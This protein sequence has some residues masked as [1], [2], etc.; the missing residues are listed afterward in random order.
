V[1]ESILKDEATISLQRCFENDCAISEAV[2]EQGT[3]SNGVVD[4]PLVGC[5]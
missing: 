2:V 5:Q 1:I 3:N 4:Q